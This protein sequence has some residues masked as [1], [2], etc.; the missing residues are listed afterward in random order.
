MHVLDFLDQTDFYSL[1][2][3][4]TGASLIPEVVP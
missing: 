1:T 2:A 4:S 3:N